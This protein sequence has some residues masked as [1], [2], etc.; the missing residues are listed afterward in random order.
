MPLLKF[1]QRSPFTPMQAAARRS[2]NVPNENNQLSYAAFVSSRSVA[3]PLQAGA[4]Q[5]RKPSISLLMYMLSAVVQATLV[6]F[7][8]KGMG[9][10][11]TLLLYHGWKIKLLSLL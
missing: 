10:K 5:H 2:K 7:K 11:I 8:Y 4:K 3:S 6:K 1:A 9:K